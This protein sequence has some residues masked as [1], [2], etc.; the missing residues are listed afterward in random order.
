MYLLFVV[1]GSSPEQFVPMETLARKLK[2]RAEQLGVSNAEAARRAGLDD[3]HY[4]AGRREPNLATLVT[5]AKALGTS[6][7]WLLGLKDEEELEM[8]RSDLLERLAAAARALRE[9]ELRALTIQAEALATAMR[10]SA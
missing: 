6:P 5:I 7:D 4:T 2:E 3:A 1:S 9:P 8:P 10:S